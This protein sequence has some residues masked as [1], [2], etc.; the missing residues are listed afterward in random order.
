MKKTSS[1]PFTYTEPYVWSI[2]FGTPAQWNSYS[3]ISYGNYQPNLAD[4]NLVCA[5]IGNGYNN[6]FNIDNGKIILP[7]QTALG[8]IIEPE[9]KTSGATYDCEVMVHYDNY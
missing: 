3:T 4:G 7:R 2:V 9:D 6:T 5:G 1:S 8:F